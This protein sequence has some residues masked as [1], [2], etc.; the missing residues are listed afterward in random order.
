MSQ[1]LS[2]GD[3]S[4]MGL[5]DHLRELRT[6]L[7]RS[8]WGLLLGFVICY[9]FTDLLFDIIRTPIAPYLPAGGLVFTGPVDKFFAHIKV[10]FF[11]G[12][13]LSSPWWLY[14]VWRFIAP[15][16][17]QSER[18]LGIQ[19]I[20]IGTFL[21]SVG[22]SFTYFIVFPMAFK[23]LMTYGGDT[24]KPMITIDQYLNFFLW[25]CI[26]FGAAF[27]LP[28]ILVTLGLLGLVSHQ[29][30]KV[31]RKYAIVLLSIV[32]AVITPPDLV[33]MLL[34]LGPMWLLYDTSTFLVGFLERRRNSRSTNE[35]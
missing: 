20:S 30:L 21:F 16:L 14:Q 5:I 34:M 23:F 6:S 29:F 28:L 22:I 10:A 26:S 32:T 7:V 19:F 4:A 33:S 3:S 8:L 27:E 17:Y 18:R 35:V 24:D 11:G 13:L 2:H 31:N 15:G 1:A 12:V 25:T 9:Q